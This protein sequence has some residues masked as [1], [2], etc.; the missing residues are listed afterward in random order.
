MIGQ[1]SVVV[2]S[3]DLGTRVSGIKSLSRCSLA[4]LPWAR[5]LLVLC[6]FLLS[7]TGI[8]IV[9]NSKVHFCLIFEMHADQCLAHRKCC[10]M[11]C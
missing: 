8:M 11:I 2:K 10:K 9:P 7:K 1:D 5:V 3:I 6:P 4:V